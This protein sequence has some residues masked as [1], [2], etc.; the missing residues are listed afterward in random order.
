MPENAFVPASK[1]INCI[2]VTIYSQ[3]NKLWL[4]IWDNLGV[5]ETNSIRWVKLYKSFI[6]LYDLFSNYAWI[7]CIIKVGVAC[8]CLK[9]AWAVAEMTYEE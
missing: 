7:T 6:S 9:E 2:H 3:L 8:S 1:I 4:M 5:I